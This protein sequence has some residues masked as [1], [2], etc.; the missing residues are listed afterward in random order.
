MSIGVSKIASPRR[1]RF[2]ATEARRANT[3]FAGA[4]SSA[5]ITWALDRFGPRLLLASS[6][7]DSL[8][9]DVALKVDPDIEVL[10][11]DTGFHFAETLETVRLAM[12]RYA[13][14]LTVLRPEGPGPNVWVN[15]SEACCHSRKVAPLD[16]YLT[17]HG[18]AWMS[19]LRRSDDPSRAN[20]PIVAVDS[21]GLAKINPLVEWTDRQAAAY[22]S[23]HEILVNPLIAQGYP[24]IGCWPCT[25]K[26][27][28]G[29]DG[30]WAGSSKTECGLHL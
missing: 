7:A 22:S 26:A 11:L 23:S 13:L 10:F 18:D 24:S 17:A 8:L 1:T 19:G 5:I 15:N 4:D 25:D 14:N 9:I 28:A 30:R 6:F 2:T 21:R 20:T 29:R 16:K 3:E 27:T 12:D